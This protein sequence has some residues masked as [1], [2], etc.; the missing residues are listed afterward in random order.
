MVIVSKELR[1]LAGDDK[2]FDKYITRLQM[3]TYI[4]TED[5]VY[6]KSKDGRQYGWGV[7]VYSTP[8]HLYGRGLV[9]S[10]YKTPPEQYRKIIV[11]KIRSHFPDSDEK[12]I[13]KLIK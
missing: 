10:Q 2:S 7:A 8:E 3:Q 12:A 11:E 6:E 4:V 5:F 13:L 1:K 9:T